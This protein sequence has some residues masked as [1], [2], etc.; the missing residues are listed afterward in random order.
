M[1]SFFLAL[2]LN[3]HVLALPPLRCNRHLSNHTRSA[4]RYYVNTLTD[5]TSWEKP[6]AE[7][8][9]AAAVSQR[10]NL[11]DHDNLIV[12]VLSVL[13][14]MMYENDANIGRF[15]AAS[16]VPTYVFLR[17]YVSASFDCGLFK[18][19]SLCLYGALSLATAATSHSLAPP[20]LP[21][22]PPPSRRRRYE[23][24]MQVFRSKPKTLEATMC[25]LSN[26]M[27][28]SDENKLLI[29]QVRRHMTHT[30]RDAQIP[31]I[32]LSATHSPTHSATHS[33]TCN[34]LTPTNQL[35]V[36]HSNACA[37]E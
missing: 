29:G 31:P 25:G 28:I 37:H 24:T 4:R 5:E 33:P 36:M 7:E 3:T 35:H 23:K 1:V 20:P 12:A 34:G 14:N 16:G 30:H 10:G 8:L 6:S 9:N 22:C 17:V 2:M 19:R 13:A 21:S 26:A 11:S 27:Y 18:S 32:S 15:I